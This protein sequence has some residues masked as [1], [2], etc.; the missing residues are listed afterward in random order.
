MSEIVHSLA[1]KRFDKNPLIARALAAVAAEESFSVVRASSQI[2][3]R[4]FCP[5]I[6]SPLGDEDF[7]ALASDAQELTQERALR[8]LE[9]IIDEIS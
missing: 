5:S 4:V 7:F 2:S 1:T 6:V 8:A 3:S 9:K